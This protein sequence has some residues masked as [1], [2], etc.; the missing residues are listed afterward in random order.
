MISPA[1]IRWFSYRGFADRVDD[2]IERHDH[3]LEL[4]AQAQSQRKIGRC[5]RAR[6]GDR[7]RSQ[8]VDRPLLAGHDHRAIAIAHARPARAKHVF[9]RPD[10]HKRAS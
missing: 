8:L 9:D 6:H 5:Q 2:S 4:L 7:E 10:A 1:S 3:V